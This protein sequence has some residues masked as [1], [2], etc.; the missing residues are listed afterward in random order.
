MSR[1]SNTLRASVTSEAGGVNLCPDGEPTSDLNLWT[2]TGTATLGFVADAMTVA[3]PSPIGID[4]CGSV[5]WNADDGET[6]VV[7]NDGS[8]LAGD[9]YTVSMWVFVP[10]G[11]T[12]VT[13]NAD[14]NLSTPMGSVNF[15]TWTRLSLTWTAASATPA[16]ALQPDD[17]ADNPGSVVYWTG[18][19]IQPGASLSNYSN[20]G[21]QPGD[22]VQ[23]LVDGSDT[24]ITANGLTGYIPTPGDRLLVQRVGGQMEVVQWLS[25]GTV[26]Y[27]TDIDLS[28]LSAQVNSN[29]D[30][31]TDNAN[32]IAAVND[33]LTNYM[34][35]TDVTLSGLQDGFDVLT[36]LG[37]AGVQEDYMFV[38]D[39]P[40]LS[41]IKLVQ[42]S[43]YVQGGLYAGDF[44]TFSAYF[45]LWTRDDLGDVTFS[46][47]VLPPMS[48][49]YT[50]F[51]NNGLLAE[52]WN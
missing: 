45:N 29:T 47:S 30:S 6:L 40:T 22:P 24:P 51:T 16:I 38:G 32:N 10:S 12:T 49:F 50:V 48:T 20:G 23:V 33:T 9:V 26:P 4:G 25:R 27:L 7:P 28:D 11:N 36:G 17:V 41:T 42:I 31:V 52:P 21:G 43:T 14:G 34:G 2:V 35:T 44:P 39:D 1:P 37:N 8:M 13:L 3:D 5:T 15:D 19:M 46:G 18:A